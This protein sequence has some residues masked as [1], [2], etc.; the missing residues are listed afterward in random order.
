MFTMWCR[1]KWGVTKMIKHCPVC[2]LLILPHVGIRHKGV[3]W[4]KCEVTISILPQ[5][6]YISDKQLRCHSCGTA[7]FKRDIVYPQEWV[8]YGLGWECYDSNSTV[9][10][11]WIYRC[12]RCFETKKVKVE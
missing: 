11:S 6:Q 12:P 10:K 3:K 4:C 9:I 7:L 1:F 8:Q 2:G 5:K